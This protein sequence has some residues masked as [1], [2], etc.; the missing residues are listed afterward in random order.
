MFSRNIPPQ[1]SPIYAHMLYGLFVLNNKTHQTEIAISYANLLLSCPAEYLDYDDWY[2]I[3]LFCG[4]YSSGVK[5]SFDKAIYHFTQANI[6][7]SGKWK[8]YLKEISL[9]KDF[10]KLSDYLNFRITYE[11]KMQEIILENNLHS[12]HYITSLKNAY[13]ELEC[14]YEKMKEFSLTDSL[15]GLNN[16]RFLWKKKNEFITLAYEQ[17]APIGCLMIDFDDFKSINDT[18]GHI[19]GD[20][21]IKKVSQTIKSH[22]RK[23]D[24]VVRFGGEEILVL[25]FNTPKNDSLRIAEDLRQLIENLL[26]IATNEERIQV[27]VSIGVSTTDNI[28]SLDM[29]IIDKLIE[30]ADRFL[31]DAK[32]SGK[33]RVILQE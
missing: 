2:S 3:H 23:S 25:M 16:R 11:D 1:I 15:T 10:L 26:I 20:K 29:D 27:T 12:N 31:F 18:Y 30:K 21:V 7:L 32:R 33:N 5:K 13:E 14:M 24:I 6:F 28:Q 8:A 22:F 19:E 4:E 9:L 17:K